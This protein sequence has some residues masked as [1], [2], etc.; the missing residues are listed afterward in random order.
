MAVR[1]VDVVGEDFGVSRPRPRREHIERTGLDMAGRA[2]VVRE[3]PP[4]GTRSPDHAPPRTGVHG[5]ND[6][7]VFREVAD[8][9]LGLQRVS[10][11][12]GLAHGVDPYVAVTLLV[13]AH[14]VLKALPS[15]LQVG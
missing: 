8:G 9:D 13:P 7:C 1:V 14:E 6:R 3:R 5:E 11:D 4:V 15:H 2:L 10:C 12:F